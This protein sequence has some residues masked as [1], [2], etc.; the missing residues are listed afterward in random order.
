MSIF[1]IFLSG[2]FIGSFLNVL[3][4]RLPNGRSI[5]GRSECDHCHKTLN[6][7]D[8]IPIISFIYLKGKCRYCHHKLSYE[9]PLLEITTGTLF[10]LT[11][12][13]VNLKFFLSIVNLETLLMSDVLVVLTSVPLTSFMLASYLFALSIISIFI[14]IF[15]ADLKYGIIP[16]RMLLPAAVIISLW[17]IIFD[18]PQIINHLLSGLGAFLFFLLIF[19]LTRGR[20]MGFG[21]VKFAFIIGLLLGFPGTVLALYIAFL[22]GGIIGIIL[23]LWKKKRL[24]SAV[25]FGPFLVAGTLISFFLSPLVI[26]W[27]IQFF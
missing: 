25:S 20:G 12:L 27:L 2:L 8:L 3:I 22:T 4:N 10:V 26:P 19:G 17:L 1:F 14:V 16:D 9:Y 24:K 11:Y 5:L 13:L 15:F 18:Q 6:W 7:R 23:I 21:D